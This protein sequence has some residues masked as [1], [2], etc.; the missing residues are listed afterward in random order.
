MTASPLGAGRLSFANMYQIG[1]VVRDVDRAAARFCEMFGIERFRIIRHGPDI[2]TAHAYVGDMMIELIEV[3]P[4]GPGYFQAYIPDDPDR[5][6]FHHHAYR[7][8]DAAEFERLNAAARDL[9][10]PY[11]TTSVKDGELNVLFVDLRGV[12]GAYAEYVYLKGTMLSYYD[13]VPRS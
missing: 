8:H 11:E 10:V 6:V 7:V 12:T 2:A 9:G 5:A 1:Y 3:G 13:D 4:G